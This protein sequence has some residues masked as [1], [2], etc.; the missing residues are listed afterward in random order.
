MARELTLTP[1]L[2]YSPSRS[3]GFCKPGRPR[4]NAETTKSFADSRQRRAAIRGTVLMR[5]RLRNPNCAS[6]QGPK[7]TVLGAHQALP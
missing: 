2:K 4:Q 6:V 3:G 5:I 1:D 7:P